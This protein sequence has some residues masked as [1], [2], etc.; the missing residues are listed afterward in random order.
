VN[1]LHGQKLLLDRRLVYDRLQKLDIPV[2]RHVCLNRD[3]VPASRY[4][5]GEDWIEVDGNRVEKPF[6]EKPVHAEDHNLYIYYSSTNGGGG[7]KLFRKVNNEASRFCPEMR[8][9]RENGSYVGEAGTHA[10]LSGGSHLLSLNSFI[11]EEFVEPDG[12]SDLKTYMV[13]ANVFV[14]TRK[15]PAVDGHV[16]RTTEGQEVR[17]VGTLSAEEMDM[18]VRIGKAFKQT[19]CGVDLLRANG[20]TCVPHSFSG[21]SLKL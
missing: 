16:E 17:H 21:C 19:V 5:Q 6:V 14:Q 12:V 4:R 11:Y 13:G 2:P 18:V 10:S 3:K 15:S 8:G 9:V 1:D 20:K 7:R